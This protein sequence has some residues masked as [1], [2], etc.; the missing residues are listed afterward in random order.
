MIPV[1]LYDLRWRL[2]LVGFVGI[3]FFIAEPGFHQHE[4]F[5][6]TAVALGPLG[7]SASLANLAGLSMLIL[8]AGTVSTDR[9]EGYYRILFAQ[10]TSPLAYYGLR[11]G[12][13]LAVSLAAAVILLVFGQIFAW[14]TFR[15]GWSG[16]ILPLLSALVYGGLIIFFSVLLP[17]GEAWVVFVL[18]LPTFI[19]E[20]RTVGLQAL[21]APVR[22][23]ITFLL[24]PQDALQ[25]VWQGLLLGTPDAGAAIFAAMYGL[26][27]LLAAGLLLKSREWG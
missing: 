26:I 12:L 18:L 13:A 25:S 7:I 27:F 3:V 23:L 14:G 15:G 11:W 5:D 6:P 16:M 9:R 22:Q 19:P 1:I 8:L 4:G 24:P 21:A 17:R 10:P 20:I 2:L